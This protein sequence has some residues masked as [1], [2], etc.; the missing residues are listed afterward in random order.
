[1]AVHGTVSEPDAAM[2]VVI[3]NF[4]RV[5]LERKIARV[6]R[7]VGIKN[8]IQAGLRP[9]GVD[10]IGEMAAADFDPNAVGVTGEGDGIGRGEG[11]VEERGK[12]DQQREKARAEAHGSGR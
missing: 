6:A 2:P 4:S 3:G 7:A 1:M 8:W 10:V 5:F 12:R 9:T 11:C